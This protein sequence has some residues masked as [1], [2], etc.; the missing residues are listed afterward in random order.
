[1]DASYSRNN[2]N[3]KLTSSN[4]DKCNTRTASKRM[5]VCQK[6]GTTA[7]IGTTTKEGGDQ[8]G[9]LQKRGVCISRDACK[10]NRTDAC[11]MQRCQKM[12]T[13]AKTSAF[14]SLDINSKTSF[15]IEDAMHRS[16][17]DR[18]RGTPAAVWRTPIKTG[19]LI[20]SAR[21]HRHDE[22]LS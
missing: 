18:K 16:L 3:S 4:V 8:Q 6:A 20:G 17:N 12:T 11:N 13:T 7:R 2:S 1:M 22:K 14:R 19:H 10:F 15:N 5:D 21:I 9:R